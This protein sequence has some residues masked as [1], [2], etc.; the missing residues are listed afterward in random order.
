MSE[1]DDWVTVSDDIDVEYM[2]T[3]AVEAIIKAIWPASEDDSLSFALRSDLVSFR[4]RCRRHLYLRAEGL[5][6][7]RLVWV[8]GAPT[9]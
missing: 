7:P 1:V 5:K 9:R 2:T 4:D 3:Q 6:R 8:N